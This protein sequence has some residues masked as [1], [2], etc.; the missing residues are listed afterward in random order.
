MKLFII[1]LIYMIMCLPLIACE[2]GSLDGQGNITG[3]ISYDTIIPEASQQYA[4]EMINSIVAAANPKSDEEP[5]DNIREARETVLELLGE[6]VIGIKFRTNSIWT[7]I[8]YKQLSG[9]QKMLVDKWL[10][11]K[12]V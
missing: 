7:F 2:P 5:E 10:K 11:E 6:R 3:Y 12:G 1:L 8:P 4:L 9:K